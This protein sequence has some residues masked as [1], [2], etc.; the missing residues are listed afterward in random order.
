MEDEW[1]FQENYFD[2]VHIRCMSGSFA[3]WDAVL[4]QAYR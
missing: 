2:Y 3:D 4:A 1:T